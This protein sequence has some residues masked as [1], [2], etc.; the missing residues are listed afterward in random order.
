MGSGA[1][2]K[3]MRS[4]SLPRHAHG[5]RGISSARAHRR[6]RKPVG[7]GNSVH[8]RT[9]RHGRRPRPVPLGSPDVVVGP[10]SILRQDAINAVSVWTSAWH[11]HE[12]TRGRRQHHQSRKSSSEGRLSRHLR[13]KGARRARQ[14]RLG[15]V[16]G[17]RGAAVLMCV[18]GAAHDVP[19]AQ[20]GES[21]GAID[22][23]HSHIARG[24]EGC[25][26]ATGW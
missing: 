18:H 14:R 26:L 5:A 21:A 9:Y 23:W 16:Q 13:R 8:A 4:S 20:H 22:P 24:A 12:T 19:S 15:G 7:G 2:E 11:G 17:A 1:A 6:R 25:Q 3:A 10:A